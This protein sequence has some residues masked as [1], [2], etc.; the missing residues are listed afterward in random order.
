MEVF[1][2]FQKL[3][4]LGSGGFRGGGGRPLAPYPYGGYGGPRGG[5]VDTPPPPLRFGGKSKIGNNSYFFVTTLNPSQKKKKSYRSL[6]YKNVIKDKMTRKLR[7]NLENQETCK[8]VKIEV[9]E[10]KR[11]Q[12]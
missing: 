10:P 6:S 7:K 11:A 4:F 1:Y 8:K 9:T 5:T 2:F 12:Y 3:V